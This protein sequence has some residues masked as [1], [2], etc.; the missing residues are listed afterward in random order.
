MF[1]FFLPFLL[2]HPHS[3][4]QLGQK[5]YSLK[6]INGISN[7]RSTLVVLLMLGDL[8]FICLRP[9]SICLDC[10]WFKID[11]LCSIL[12]VTVQGLHSLS[13]LLVALCTV[14]L[15]FLTAGDGV[16]PGID[17]PAVVASGELPYCEWNVL[18][19][20]VRSRENCPLSAVTRP[21]PP[22]RLASV[23]RARDNVLA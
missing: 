6:E 8:H 13:W 2:L 11:L 3:P 21:K 14:N 15:G 20:G 4:L 19:F 17:Y 1:D 22:C 7:I 9:C 5:Y 23:P 16:K 18:I 10:I 12:S